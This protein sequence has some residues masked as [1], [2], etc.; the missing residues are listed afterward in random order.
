MRSADHH[1]VPAPLQAAP[2][3]RPVGEAGGVRGAAR[4]G[5]GTRLRWGHVRPA[6]PFFLPR[7]NFVPTGH[8]QVRGRDR[9]RVR[10]LSYKSRPSWNGGPRATVPRTRH[11]PLLLA[12]KTREDSCVQVVS[13]LE[14][15]PPGHRSTYEASSTYPGAE[16]APLVAPQGVAGR[17]RRGGKAAQ[18]L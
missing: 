5:R 1:P 2:P 6:G 13:K 10:I 16:G 3:D 18:G 4:G 12:P 17:P 11:R 8:G 9:R 14:R 15:W 7:G